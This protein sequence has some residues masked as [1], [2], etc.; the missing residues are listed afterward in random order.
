MQAFERRAR[1]WSEQV[2][3]VPFP[4]HFEELPDRT[5]LHPGSGLALHVLDVVEQFQRFRI[6]L[7]QQFFKITFETQMPAVEHERIDVAPHL[8]Q[9][10]NR[11]DFAVEIGGGGNRNVRPNLWAAMFSRWDS[12]PLRHG[13]LD[14]RFAKHVLRKN[15]L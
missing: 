6:A 10:G 15:L 11:P 14:E 7:R 1:S 8:S 13:R 2:K 12:G 3:G 5:R 9:M 4:L